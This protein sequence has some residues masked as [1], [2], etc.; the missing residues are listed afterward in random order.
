LGEEPRTFEVTLNEEGRRI[1][2]LLSG[3]LPNLSR[4]QIQRLIREQCVLVDRKP[5]KTSFRPRRGDRIHVEMPQAAPSEL[6]PEDIPI[7]VLYETADLLVLNKPPGLV[8]HPAPGHGTGTLVN[9]LLHH[10]RDLSGIG[11]VIRPGLVHRL[12]KDTSG[13]LLIAKNDHAHDR[14]ARL[15]KEGRIE[16]TY[17]ALVHGNVSPSRASIDFPIG[18]HPVHRKKMSIVSRSAKRAFTTYM[19]MHRFASVPVSYV[20]VRIQTGRTHQIRV[21]MSAVGHPVLGDPVYGGRRDTD[22]ILK[23]AGSP[24]SRQMLHAL[25]LRWREPDGNGSVSVEAPVP[26]DMRFVLSALEVLDGRA[27]NDGADR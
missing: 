11:G 1:D 18:R 20:R 24:V 4:S 27:E 3:L 6:Q 26:D 7:S 12:D 2:A 9:A 17:V 10:V 8:V 22:R 5:V 16:K 13:V 14:L 23:Q 19:V 21:H 25:R 15:F